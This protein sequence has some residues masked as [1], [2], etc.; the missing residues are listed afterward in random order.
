MLLQEAPDGVK[1]PVGFASKKLLD[2]ERN[3]S[4]IETECLG[5]IREIRKFQEFLHGQPFILETDH[6][7]LQYLGKNQFQSGRLMH[8]ALAL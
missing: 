1:H 5:I 4:T 7:P 2:R 3:Y 8:W 6:M